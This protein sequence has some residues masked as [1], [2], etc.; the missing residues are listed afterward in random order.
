MPAEKPKPP[1]GR[2]E[3][4]AHHAQRP[5]PLGGLDQDIEF[6]SD[7]Q[8]KNDYKRHN[9]RFLVLFFSRRSLQGVSLECFPGVSP[10]VPHKWGRPSLE[11]VA[12]FVN[13]VP[14][15]FEPISQNAFEVGSA[16]GGRSQKS[17]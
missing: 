3:Q 16:G 13:F 4:E 2:Q 6:Q 12:C 14:R 15:S 8:K 9:T 1:P 10:R 11:A 5:D 17:V 7:K